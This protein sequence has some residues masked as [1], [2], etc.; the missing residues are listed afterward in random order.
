MKLFRQRTSHD[1]PL[2]EV[3]QPRRHFFEAKRE[4]GPLARSRNCS[5]RSSEAIGSQQNESERRVARTGPSEW[6]HGGQ[7]R[8][9]KSL[10]GLKQAA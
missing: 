2:G 3:R 1:R 6:W 4:R 5:G 9:L 10:Y 7:L 8:L